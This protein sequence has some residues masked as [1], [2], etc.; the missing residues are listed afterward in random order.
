MG[1]TPQAISA[2]PGWQSSGAL[3]ACLTAWEKR[4]SDLAYEVSTIGQNLGT[5]N[6]N[7]RAA[8]Q[9]IVTRLK[10]LAELIQGTEK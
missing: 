4:L 9:R 6:H 3:Q 7:Y 5:A 2:H 10:A 1:S 8:D